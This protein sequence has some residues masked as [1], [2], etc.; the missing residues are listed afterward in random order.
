MLQKVG[1]KRA[2]KLKTLSKEE[3]NKMFSS[4]GFKGKHHS[5]E[6]KAKIGKSN[7]NK[8]PWNKGIPRSEET[9]QKIRDAFRLKQTGQ[10]R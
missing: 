6:S 4:N 10:N 8:I 5:E 9:K 2:E 1:K 3:W 7:S